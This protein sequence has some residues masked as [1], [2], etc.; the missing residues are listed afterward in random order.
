MAFHSIWEKSKWIT[1]TH[2]TWPGVTPN[3]H[4]K[5]ILNP[6]HFISRILSNDT[7]LLCFSHLP[8]LF[9][10]QE[11]DA[12]CPLFQECSSCG[13]HPFSPF[14]T[15]RPSL[16]K[17]FPWSYNEGAPTFPHLYTFFPPTRIFLVI[18]WT[19]SELST[20]P[21]C[22]QSTSPL[23][24]A[25]AFSSKPPFPHPWPYSRWEVTRVCRNLFSVI[26]VSVFSA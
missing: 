17:C 3:E 14:S 26:L 5:L 11:H 1:S 20:S 10:P 8:N 2:R 24:F 6:L 16:L 21:P 9:L 23:F 22:D 4:C 7:Y 15:Q 13:W 12:S 19:S 18:P 25:I